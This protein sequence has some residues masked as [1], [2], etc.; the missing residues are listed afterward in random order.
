MG[1]VLHGIDLDGFRQREAAKGLA[2]S[3]FYAVSQVYRLDEINWHTASPE[4]QD[5]YIALAGAF[6]ES[7]RPEPKHYYASCLRGIVPSPVIGEIYEA[8]K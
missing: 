2:M 4:L 3:M 7:K 6:L 5:H 8:P 1:A